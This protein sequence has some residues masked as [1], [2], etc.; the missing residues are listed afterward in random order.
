MLN[1]NLYNAVNK[2][3]EGFSSL[4]NKLGRRSEVEMKA[5]DIVCPS[6]MNVM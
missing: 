4:K 2:N 1:K 3:S 5:H 6:I